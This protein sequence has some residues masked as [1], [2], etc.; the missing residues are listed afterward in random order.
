MFGQSMFVV[1][2]RGVTWLPFYIEIFNGTQ[3]WQTKFMIILRPV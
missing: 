1:L 3:L 2:E